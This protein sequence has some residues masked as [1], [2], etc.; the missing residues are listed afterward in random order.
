MFKSR[1]NTII[2][3]IFST[4]FLVIIDQL[5]KMWVVNTLMDKDP[6]ILIDNVFEFRYHGN[7]G[8][9]WSTLIGQRTLFLVLTPIILALVFVGFYR[10]SDINKFTDIKI[11][12]IFLTAG[13]IGNYIDRAF[14]NGIVIDF[15]YFSLINFP[16]FNIADCY[17]TCSVFTLL[18][19]ILFKYK[20]DELDEFSK[21]ALKRRK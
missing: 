6:I 14:N 8:A 1:K 3:G 4:I 20:E 16:I 15:L 13:A 11:I 5:S 7:P 18:F 12:A 21:I 9:M 2:I 17:I 19:I 10:I